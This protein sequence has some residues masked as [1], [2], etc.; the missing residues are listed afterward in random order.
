[1]RKALSLAALVFAGVLALDTLLWW[2][3]VRFL[4]HGLAGIDAGA[5]AGAGTGTGIGTPRS[6]GCPVS[7]QH[8]TRGGWPFQARLS[9]EGVQ[10]TCGA[11]SENGRLSYG[12]PHATLDLAPWHPLTVRG[13]LEGGQ[14]LALATHSSGDAVVQ[15]PVLH[16]PVL[17]KIEGAPVQ[18][19]LPLRV[20]DAGALTFRTEFLHLVPQSGAAEAHPVT[21]RNATGKLVWNRH[22][23][24]QASALGFSFTAQRAIVA[25]WAESVDDVSGAV[26]IPGPMARLSALWPQDDVTASDPVSSENSSAGQGVSVASPGYAE[27]LVQHMSGRW[28]GLGL[29]WSG[30]LVMAAGGAPLGDTWLTLNNWRLFLARLQQ[31]QTL[32]PAQTALLAR[33]TEQLEQS[34]RGTEGPLTVPLQVRDSAVQLG[35]ISLLSLL[36][37][38]HGVSVSGAGAP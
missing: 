7:V 10:I 37:T 38:L 12:V 23:D 18:V 6:A 17:L 35:G 13:T 21:A 14:V 31:D 11:S 29:S 9:L 33:L 16:K 26:S 24:A 22:A 19:F 4:E 15:S 8:K 20:A 34:T 28:R 30:R 2:G 27:F 36:A 32:T 3:G 25:P 5:S 1:M